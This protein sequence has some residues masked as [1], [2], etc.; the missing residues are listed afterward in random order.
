MSE[1]LEIQRQLDIA[2]KRV[3][4]LERSR[5]DHPEYPSIAANLESARRIKQKLEVQLAEVSAKGNGASNQCD[6]VANVSK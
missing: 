6:T 2:N 4:A 1:L 5:V 3:A